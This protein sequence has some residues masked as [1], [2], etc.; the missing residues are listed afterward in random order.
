MP[1][2]RGGRVAHWVKRLDSIVMV[3]VLSLGIYA[4]LFPFPVTSLSLSYAHG[5]NMQ[6]GF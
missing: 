6:A 5:N 2:L 3:P 1:D 4:A